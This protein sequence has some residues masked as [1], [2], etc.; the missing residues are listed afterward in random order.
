MLDTMQEALYRDQDLEVRED[1]AVSRED[2]GASLPHPLLDWE[3]A[4][5]P[6]HLSPR[7]RPS[8]LRSLSLLPLP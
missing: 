7:H 5:Q 8:Y 3:E 6:V 1:L 2:L 4:V